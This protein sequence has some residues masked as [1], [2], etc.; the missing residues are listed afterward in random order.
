MQ[1]YYTFYK[2][3]NKQN[4]KVY[5]GITSKTLQERV[6]DYREEMKKSNKRSF[7]RAL[8][9]FG[10]SGFTWGEIQTAKKYYNEYEAKGYEMQI[11]SDLVKA[12]G[13]D[14]VYNDITSWPEYYAKNPEKKRQWRK[15]GEPKII[16]KQTIIEKPIV[17]T[18]EVIKEVPKPVIVEK[19][20]EKHIIVEKPVVQN[21]IEAPQPVPALPAPNNR[22]LS[23]LQTATIVIIGVICASLIFVFVINNSSTDITDTIN[24]P[25]VKAVQFSTCEEA[26][27]AGH[28]NL[29]FQ[30]AR[31]LGLD[32]NKSDGDGDGKHCEPQPRGSANNADVLFSNCTE[33]K[34]AGYQRFNK[35]TAERILTN[36]ASADRDKDGLY[37]E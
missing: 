1:N 33:A 26:N 17:I 30:E 32:I 10:I 37:C 25:D 29:T 14:N 15:Y 16:E 18:K 35:E 31:D 13:R 27:Q 24:T 11:I 3:T 21:A 5:I 34:S 23:P 12:K 6:Q 7:V 4:G 9:Q 2:A 20:V 22:L 36:P 28:A 19:P 8:E